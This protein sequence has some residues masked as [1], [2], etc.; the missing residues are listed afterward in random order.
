MMEEHGQSLVS[1]MIVVGVAFL[2][3]IV[4]ERFR[5]RALPVVVAEI[6]AGLL[7]GKSGFDLIGHDPWLELLSLFG[8]IYLMF[9]SGL[10][11]DFS[12]FGG[13]R[14]KKNGPNAPVTASILFLFILVISYG[15]S[16]LLVQ[17]KMAEDPYLM[18]I[19]I[20]TISLGVV[21]PVL[22]EKKLLSEPVGQVLLLTTVIADFVSMILLSVYIAVQAGSVVSLLLLILFF[23]VVAGVYVLIKR[24]SIPALTKLLGHGTIQLGMRA[25]FALL[26]LLVVVSE[27]LGVENILGAFL[28]GVTVSLL[29]PSKTFVRQLDSF[30]YGFLIPI[31]FMMVGI[32]LEIW[33]LFADWRVL[34]LIPVLLIFLFVSKIVPALL[35]RVWFDWKTVLGSGALLSSTL[36]L[37]IAASTIALEL[38]LITDAVYGALILVAIVSCIIFPVV[39]NRLMPEA[40]KKPLSVGIVGANHMTLPI[41][42]DLAAHNF[43]VSLYSASYTEQDRAQVGKSGVKFTDVPS[44]EEKVLADKGLFDHEIVVLGTSDDADNIRLAEAARASGKERIVVRIED[45]SLYEQYYGQGYTVFSTLHA[46]RTL[47]RALVEQP[48]MVRLFSNERDTTREIVLGNS[49]YHNELLRNLPNLTGV[50]VLRV[51]R[52]DSFLIPHGNTELLLGD[53][54]LVSGGPDELDKLTAALT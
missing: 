54:L 17:M 44:L 22:K 35:L 34:M 38:E 15:L 46:S 11:I 21:V 7:L 19:I 8:F 39:F 25:T 12:A 28:A 18:T 31:F 26:L 41:A 1:L 29:G 4:L 33:G 45:P 53:R 32:N 20:S 9:L 36:S 16:L 24:F 40:E 43:R 49:H 37:V 10:E 3:P 51:Y 6:I 30:G 27:S 13:R 14:A 52:N 5:I 2:I 48:T 42:P 50:L 47:L 23:A